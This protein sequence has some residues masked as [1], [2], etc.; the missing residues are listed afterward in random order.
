MRISLF[1]MILSGI[2]ISVFAQNEPYSGG[3]GSGYTK[4]EATVKTMSGQVFWVGG[5]ASN[6]TSWN[7]PLNWF[8]NTA[9]PGNTDRISFDL[10]G[11]ANGL[12]LDQ[13]RTVSAV[14]FNGSGKKIEL[15][16]YVLTVTGSISGANSTNYFKTASG[17]TLAKNLSNNEN[18]LFPVGNAAYNPVTITNNTGSADVFSVRVADQVLMSGTTGSEVSSRRVNRTWHISKTNP[19]ASA[20][21]GVDFQFEWS[22]SEETATMSSINLN[23]HDG[24]IWVL[25][26]SYGGSELVSG[27]TTKTLTFSGYKGGFSPFAIGEISAALPVDWLTFTGR[28]GQQS[29]ILQWSTASE[30]M[31]SHF[32]VERSMNGISFFSIGKIIAAG[33]SAV[34][35]RYQFRDDKPLAGLAYYRLKQ[36]DL[37]GQFNYSSIINV[38]S[39]LDT[40]ASI[41]PNPMLTNLSIVI[42]AEWKSSYQWTIHDIRGVQIDQGNG[43]RAGIRLLSVEHLHSGLY[44]FSLRDNER[45]I[46]QCWIMKQ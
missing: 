7:D 36:V 40:K 16:A 14:D 3:S 19:T 41:G 24:T 42:P 11:T 6:P 25:A 33:N 12:V 31:S 27:S 44:R 13:N 4:A 18:F 10:N 32:D 34:V 26:S 22:S 38:S 1:T 35:R 8:P 28:Y 23:H 29:V 43:L 37:N 45:I 46:Q 2:S 21:S 9:V 17:G 39:R 15:G 20:G 30:Q 5:A